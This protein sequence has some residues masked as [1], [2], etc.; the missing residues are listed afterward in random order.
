MYVLGQMVAAVKPDGQVLD[1]QVIRPNPVVEV[2][3]RVVC[4]IDGRPLFVMADAATAAVDEHVRRGLLMEE[5]V[6]DHDVREHYT[7]GVDLI[8]AY[9]TKRRRLPRDELQ[10]LRALAGSCA[11]RERC[12]LRRLRVR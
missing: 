3:G 10:A 1:L 4:E 12:R 2:D 11:V 8:A 7:D 9:A 5:E 6:D